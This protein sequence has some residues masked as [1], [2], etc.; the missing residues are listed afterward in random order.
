ME[1]AM[2]EQRIAH[3]TAA[4]RPAVR[5][6]R[7]YVSAERPELSAPV[8]C[9]I[10]QIVSLLAAIVMRDFLR[11]HKQDK[12]GALGSVANNTMYHDIQ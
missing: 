2:K 5:Y 9:P 1:N 6:A 11:R 3:V 8:L 12:R 4:T 7:A 10:L